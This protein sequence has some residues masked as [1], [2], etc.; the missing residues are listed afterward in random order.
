MKYQIIGEAHEGAFSVDEEVFA[1]VE[2]KSEEE[3]LYDFAKITSKIYWDKEKGYT[4]NHIR[5][6][7]AKELT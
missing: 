3:A 2:A 4:I 6:L 1:I 7:T 5:K